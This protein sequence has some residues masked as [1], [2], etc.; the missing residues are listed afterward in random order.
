[1]KTNSLILAFF[2]LSFTYAFGQDE[3]TT[4][5]L[6]AYRYQM[7]STALG[8]K[9]YFGGGSIVTGVSS[10]VDIYDI[11]SQQWTSDH[12][13][14]AR[15]FPVAVSC[16]SKVFFAGGI[17]SSG[18]TTSSVQIF[19]TLTQLWSSAQLSQARFSMAAVSKGNM[20]VFAGGG[21]LS[22][23]KEYAVVD[24]YNTETDQWTTAT[25]SEARGAMGST[26]IGELAFFAG[27]FNF[28]TGTVT[29]KIDIYNFSTGTWS[30]AMLSEPRFFIGAVTVG[31]KALFAGGSDANGVP[32]RRV[33]IYDITTNTWSIDSLSVARGFLEDENTASV[34]G[35]AY[36]VGGM[37]IETENYTFTGDYNAIDIYDE[38]SGNWSTGSLPYNLF[39]HSVASAGNHLLIAGG[40]TLSGEYIQ[41]HAQVNILTCTTVSIEEVPNQL[42][43]VNLYPNPATGFITFDLA[44]VAATKAELFIYNTSG[45]LRIQLPVTHS[46]QL[47]ISVDDIGSDGMY[48]YTVRT[49]DQQ[50]FA[51]K[52]I[53][54]R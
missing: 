27:G 21:D 40:G 25:L 3:W 24:I 32:S 23:E 20:V 50:F 49:D 13:D 41:L 10:L 53:I 47:Q 35:R 28:T 1:M 16:G 54:Q 7:G 19:D 43:A 38:V 9:V 39:D 31:N 8:N 5:N 37:T 36:F 45:V 26:V 34:C 2:L 4:T 17:L 42:T 6:S 51:G 14:I 30:T 52:F 12:F 48:F 11:N 18:A 29:D 46:A 15:S 22:M 44:K 33:D